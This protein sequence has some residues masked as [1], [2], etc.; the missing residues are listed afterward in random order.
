MNKPAITFRPAERNI[1][2]LRRK[3][4]CNKKKRKKKKV[5]NKEKG[6]KEERRY[7]KQVLKT[8]QIVI[9]DKTE[10]SNGR[11]FSGDQPDLVAVDRFATMSAEW[12]H[13][14]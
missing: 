11:R 4:Y 5:K 7:S 14:E 2:D 1:Y 3:T 10:S 6:R 12:R 9:R 13:D 8:R